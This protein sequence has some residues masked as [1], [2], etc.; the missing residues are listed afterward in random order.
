MVTDV[1]VRVE[2]L[3]SF[4]PAAQEALLVPCLLQTQFF[5]SVAAD[6][7]QQYVLDGGLDIACLSSGLAEHITDVQTY[8]AFATTEHT[9]WPPG[10]V[11]AYAEVLEVCVPLEPFY[12]AQF[13]Q[14]NFVDPGCPATMTSHVLTSYSWLRFIQEG[15]LSPDPGVQAQG[16]A[17]FD[18]HVNEGYGIYGCVAAG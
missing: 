5:N 8:L 13:G 10:L 6:G 14:Y 7:L 1:P 3:A 12:L 18:Q 15:I 17:R 11:E 4:R 9:T 2:I 16:Q